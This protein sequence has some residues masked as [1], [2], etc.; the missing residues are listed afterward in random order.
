MRKIILV[1]CLAG[2]SMMASAQKEPLQTPFAVPID[3][4]TDLITYEGVVEV[5]GHSAAML[6]KRAHDWFQTYYKNPKEVIRENDSVKFSIVGKHLFKISNP[7]DKA[8]T[9]TT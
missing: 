7:P 4:I 2:I 1:I 3:S 5:K 8:G 9:K 6:Y